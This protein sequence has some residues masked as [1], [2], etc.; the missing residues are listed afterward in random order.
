MKNKGKETGMAKKMGMDRFAGD[1]DI[2]N[3]E[4]LANI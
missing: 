2:W 3:E 4:L 1:S